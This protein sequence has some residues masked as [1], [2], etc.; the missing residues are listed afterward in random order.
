M[1]L[2][3]SHEYSRNMLIRKSIE[4]DLDDILSLR[5]AARKIMRASGN[6]F[7]WPENV[8][9]ATL[10]ESD[11][12]AEFSYIVEADGVPFATFALI[13]GPDPTYGVVYDGCGWRRGGNDY[14]VIHRL[15]SNGEMHGIMEEVLRFARGRF[16]DLRIDTH[17]DNLIVRKLLARHGFVYVGNILLS[18]GESRMAFHWL[19]D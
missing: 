4:S 2:L 10:F 7:Q 17:A 12:K 9:S 11:I 5:D 19:R 16:E 3:A 13:P 8:P 15:A 1:R 18:N 14:G 6:Q